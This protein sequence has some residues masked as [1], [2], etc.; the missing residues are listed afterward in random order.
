MSIKMKF[1]AVALAA[2]T[3]GSAT[4]ATTGAAEAKKWG[5]GPGVGIGLAAGALIGAGIASS[6]YAG[7]SYVYYGPRCHWVRQYDSWGYYAGKV[8]VCD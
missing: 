7:P 5:W 1:A 8:R 4:F 6:A 3:L 2:V